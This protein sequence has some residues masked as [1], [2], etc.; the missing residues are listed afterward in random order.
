LFLSDAYIL[1]GDKVWD[2]IGHLPDKDKTQLEERLRRVPGAHV[3]EQ[4][5]MAGP[6]RQK[7]AQTN[8]RSNS[9]SKL[10][11]PRNASPLPQTTR[12]GYPH[13]SSLSKPASMGT[14]IPQMPAGKKAH[15][16][17]RLARPSSRQTFN[18]ESEDIES[19]ERRILRPLNVSAPRQVENVEILPD[20]GPSTLP[21]TREEKRTRE[22]NDV[23]IMISNILSNDPT[24][25]VDALKK[26]QKVLEPT[27]GSGMPL[28]QS[29]Q[30]VAEHSEGLI[31]TITVQVSHVFDRVN[32]L[33]D[34]A[35]FRLA[36][37]LMQTLH[38]FFS[39]NLL[40]ESLTMDTIVTLLEELT[41]RLLQTDESFDS[42][43]K[44]ISRFINLIILKIFATARRISVLR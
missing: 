38:S 36:K 25:S 13:L 12:T 28:S 30:E 4:K 6:L 27:S 19:Q 2:T 24:R 16:P 9:P 33:L 29:F 22:S 39:H 21:F 8:L 35:N 17:S 34:P 42:N 18:K 44:E 32:E 15:L 11:G 43:V 1:L 3:D 20:P 37:H 10:A 31:E 40:A 23:G 5:E 7:A 26:I 14:T 41:L